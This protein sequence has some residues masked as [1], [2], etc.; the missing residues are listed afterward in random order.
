MK[1]FNHLEDCKLFIFLSSLQL[2]KEIFPKIAAPC[3]FY[4]KWL[5]PF[6]KFI[7]LEVQ[8]LLKSLGYSFQVELGRMEL[9]QGKIHVVAILCSYDIG[10]SYVLRVV[11]LLP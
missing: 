6:D 5:Q 11:N 4:I 10:F 1:H 7:G 2:T 8:S 3:L 9:L